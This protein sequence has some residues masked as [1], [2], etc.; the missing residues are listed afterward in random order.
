M[1]IGGV[2]RSGNFKLSPLLNRKYPEKRLRLL[3]G[4]AQ[5][6]SRA[7]LLKVAQPK[8]RTVV[9]GLRELKGLSGLSAGRGPD[10]V[11]EQEKSGIYCFGSSELL[12]QFSHLLNPHLNVPCPC[13]F[14]WLHYAC[15][16][17]FGTI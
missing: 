8:R 16:K 11:A 17:V 13:N 7:L 2:I 9:R 1:T 10:R 14:T 5:V 3:H 6:L 4:M 12:D 15:L